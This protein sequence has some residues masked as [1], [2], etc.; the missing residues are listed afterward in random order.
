MPFNIIPTVYVVPQGTVMVVEDNGKF[1]KVAEPG[2]YTCWLAKYPRRVTSWGDELNKDGIFI[3]T[4]EQT[5]VT[6]S[7]DCQ[8]R[9]SVPVTIDAHI[10]LQITDA[11]AAVYKIDVMP[12]EVRL[13][14]LSAIRSQANL[15]NFDELRPKRSEIGKAVIAEVAEDVHRWGVKILGVEINDIKYDEELAKSLM[16]ARMAESNAAAE[17]KKAESEAEVAKKK[18]EA[19]AQR[20]LMKAESDAAIAKKKAELQLEQAKTNALVEEQKMEAK[21]NLKKMEAEAELLV[22]ESRIRADSTY[23]DLQAKAEAAALKTLSEAEME[24]YTKLVELLGAEYA[25][26]LL[27]TEKIQKAYGNI[28]AA[29]DRIVVVPHDFQGIVNQ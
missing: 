29:A 23:R 8:S 1:R 26:S 12:R 2:R 18:A 10:R 20:A 24:H 5:L 3:E 28:T 17:I 11:E 19:E 15:Y 13:L 9:D 4:S 21:L 16:S 27:K 7:A 14:C 6:H 25:T 22:H